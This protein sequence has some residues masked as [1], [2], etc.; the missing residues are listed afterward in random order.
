MSMSTSVRIFSNLFLSLEKISLFDKERE[1]NQNKSMDRWDVGA[2]ILNFIS[3]LPIERLIAPRNPDKDLDELE[4]RLR[5][6]GLLTPSEIAKTAPQNQD[7]GKTSQEPAR[8]PTL[9]SETESH[10]RPPGAVMERQGLEQETLAYQENKALGEVYLLED[11][12][13][14]GCRECGE[15]SDC[16]W[17][18]SDK[19]ARYSHETMSMTT[20][21]FW[22][23]LY[24]LA[25]EIR[26]KT[27][28]ED[29]RAGSYAA[30]YPEYA[31]CVSE[32][33]RPLQEKAM[34]RIKPAVTLE[35]AKAEAAKLAQEGVAKLWQSQEK[36]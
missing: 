18:H 8:P 17:K 29:V 16:C 13:K 2:G 22:T 30:E 10:P 34:Q 24:N 11:H 31:V 33:R 20:D 6:R 3:R 12:L 32:F 28:P 25:V 9:K 15:A 26:D 1:K 19:L 27:H 36:R 4:E 23:N 7:V 5:Q 35:E 14:T 21:P